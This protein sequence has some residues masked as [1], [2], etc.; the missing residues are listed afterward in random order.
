MSTQS[1]ASEAR[2]PLVD[3]VQRGLDI[4]RRRTALGIGSIKEFARA[5]TRQGGR[6]VRGVS[7][8]AITAAEKGEASERTYLRLE[9]WLDALEREAGY[10]PGE[11]LASAEAELAAGP[12]S[13]IIEFDVEGPSSKWHVHAKA[14]KGNA[15][16]AIQALAKLIRQLREDDGDDATD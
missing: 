16:E 13:D 10:N 15:D 6:D 7:V 11:L 9:S 12:A 3:T 1:E 8:D 14:S 2:W 4:N 5:T